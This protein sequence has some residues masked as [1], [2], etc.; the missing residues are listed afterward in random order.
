MDLYEIKFFYNDVDGDKVMI[1]SDSHLQFA[2][3]QFKTKGVTVKIFASCQKKKFEDEDE[4]SPTLE[5]ST[6]K[7]HLATSAS[8]TTLASREMVTYVVKLALF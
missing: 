5:S 1:A 4:E 6:Q 8:V 3:R 7:V 2:I